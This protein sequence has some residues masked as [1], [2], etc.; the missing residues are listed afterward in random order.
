MRWFS[1]Q[2]L[3]IKFTA[4][5]GL[6]LCIPIVA[7]YILLFSNLKKTT[8]DQMVEFT[9]EEMQ[10]TYGEIQKTVD[11]C[12]M[13]TQVFLNNQS[14]LSFLT[15]LKQGEEIPTEELV[16]FYQN[17]V[18]MLERLVNSNPYLYRIRVY[19]ES[20]DFSEMMP[21][22]FH[23]Q[24]MESLSWSENYESGRWQLDY[25]D[26]VLVGLSARSSEHVMSTESRTSV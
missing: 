13:S 14:L 4:V 15:C 26:N 2:K 20:D 7:I 9:T 11:L 25:E 22:L 18:A 8:I 6:I 17:D 21:I 24:R 16:E 19:A 1:R 10:K 5:I 12:N 3:N 23:R